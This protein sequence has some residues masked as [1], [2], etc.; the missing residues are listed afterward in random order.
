M[1]T[2]LHQ[3]QMTLRHDHIAVA[4]DAA[5]HLDTG[6][7][8]GPGSLV[9]VPIASHLIKYNTGQGH[10]QVEAIKAVGDGGG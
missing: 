5:E 7:F 8:H 3:P 6:A 2:R 1:F 10:I 9:I 4:S